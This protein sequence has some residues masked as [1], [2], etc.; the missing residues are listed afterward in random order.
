MAYAFRPE[1]EALAPSGVVWSTRRAHLVVV[2]APTVPVVPRVTAA[3]YR[4]RRRLAA[5]A[6]ASLLGT[7]VFAVTGWADRRISEP[8]GDPRGTSIHAPGPPDIRP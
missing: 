6:T 5:L 7:V 4:R 8:L 3:Q 1:T 2:S